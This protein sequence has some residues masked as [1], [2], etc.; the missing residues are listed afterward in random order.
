MSRDG[1]DD[2]RED[3]PGPAGQPPE[4]RDG[5]SARPADARTQ[6]TDARTQSTDARTARPSVP[7]DRLILPRGSERQAVLARGHVHHLRES[8]ARK[9]ATIG[10]FRVV[11]ADDLQPMRSSRDAWS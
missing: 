7:M 5:R 9:L 2:I 8:E 6:A 4:P 11:R 10:M 1:R 3:A